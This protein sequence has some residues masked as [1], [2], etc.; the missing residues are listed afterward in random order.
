MFFFLVPVAP[1]ELGNFLIPLMI[2]ARDV[3]F[4]RL[5]LASW[6]LFVIGGCFELYMMIAGGVDTGW[7]FTTPLST[8]FVNTN[9]VGAAMG[10]FIAGFSSILTGV[11]FI[12]TIHRMRAPGMTW[13]G[14][15]SLNDCGSHR[16]TQH[17]RH[18]VRLRHE[19]TI[20]AAILEKVFGV[21]LLKIAAAYLLT[22]NLRCDCQHWNTAA[23]AVIET[24]EE[25][26]IARAATAGAN[27]DLAGEMCFRARGKRPCLLIPYVKPR[28]LFPLPDCIRKP[29]ERIAHYAVDRV[30][31][32]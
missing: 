9:V 31:P 22:R 2:G 21:C 11:T 10:I 4:P 18:L 20:V 24:I 16:N 13:F 12:V 30:T 28:D 8:H 29:V 19:F 26:H 14:H 23:V 7:T 25:V 27:G 3:A 6:Y 5:N 15:S 32:A 1:A 17:A